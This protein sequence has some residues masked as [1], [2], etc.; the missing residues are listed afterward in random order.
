M[1]YMLRTV[2]GEAGCLSNLR[3]R[4]LLLNKA[5]LIFALCSLLFAPCSYGQ[6]TQ[7]QDNRIKEFFYQGLQQKMVQNYQLAADYFKQVSELD[8]KNDAAYFELANI[9]MMQDKYAQAEGYIRQAVALKPNNKWYWRMLADLYRDTR[10]YTQ[11]LPVFDEL[12]RL[13]EYNPDYY[14]D[15]ASTLNMLKKADEAEKIYQQIEDKFGPSEDLAEAR[16]SSSISSGN[17]AKATSELEKSIT[18]HPDNIKN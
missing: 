6:D 15:K 5:L 9:A 17:T 16:Q 2:S 8:K 1:S 11:L 3:G 7:E 10:N 12:I 4:S 18:E 13:E 14:F